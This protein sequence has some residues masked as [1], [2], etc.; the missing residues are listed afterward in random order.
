MAD[1][2]SILNVKIELTDSLEC[3]RINTGLS[4]SVYVSM[5]FSK[6]T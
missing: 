6:A 3:T 2:V 5:D 1:W 4:S